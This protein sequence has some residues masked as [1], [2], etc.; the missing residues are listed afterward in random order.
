MRSILNL[1]AAVT[2]L[3]AAITAIAGTVRE[4]N[5]NLRERLALDAPDTIDGKL[6]TD[7]T[8]PEPAKPSRKRS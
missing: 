2:D 6:L 3:A 8:E 4:A 1:F 7:E 5:S